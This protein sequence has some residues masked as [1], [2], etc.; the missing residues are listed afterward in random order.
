VCVCMWGGGG[1]VIRTSCSQ[2][3]VGDVSTVLCRVL[4]VCSALYRRQSTRI[5]DMV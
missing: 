3:S 1:V 4:T 2:A 5:W